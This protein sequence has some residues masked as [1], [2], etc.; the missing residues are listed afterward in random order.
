MFNE[1]T[2]L[3]ESYGGLVSLAQGAGCSPT[4]AL[5]AAAIAMAESGGIPSRYNPETT[6]KGG[7]PQ[8]QGSYGLWQIYRKMHPEFAGWNLYDPATNARAMYSVSEGCRNWNP[9]STYPVAYRKYLQ[10]GPV[11]NTPP[12]IGIPRPPAGDSDSEPGVETVSMQTP[13]LSGVPPI[14]IAG[15][16]ALLAWMFLR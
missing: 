4:A 7:T 11:A 6:A 1:T 15:G 10:P 8:G 5:T 16:L 12:I 3:G 2:G 9:W 13:L 14:M